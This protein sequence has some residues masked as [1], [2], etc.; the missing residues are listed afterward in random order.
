MAL[1]YMVPAIAVILLVVVLSKLIHVFQHSHIL[2]PFG[3][4]LAVAALLPHELLHALPFGRNA[5]V[6]LY[7]VPKYLTLFV[8][9]TKPVTKSRFIFLTLLPALVL[10]WAPLLIWAFKPMYNDTV[11]TFAVFNILCSCG[12]YMNA[13]NAARQM[14]KGSIQ[15]ISGL[16]SYWY[17]PSQLMHFNK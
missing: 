5:T 6:E 3:A 4:V 10:G 15:Q 12:D 17:M 8:T 16:N 2:T 13:F 1:V 11:F 14:P 7:A 9:C